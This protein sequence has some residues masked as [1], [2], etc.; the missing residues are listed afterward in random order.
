MS[1]PFIYLYIAVG[2]SYDGKNCSDIYHVKMSTDVG[3]DTS[4]TG[5]YCDMVTDCGGWTI[6]YIGR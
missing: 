4:Y 5:I 3:T 2:C 1:I 6:R